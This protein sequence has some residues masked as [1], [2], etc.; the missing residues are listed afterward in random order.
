MQQRGTVT[1][2]REAAA[3]LLL[4]ALRVDAKRCRDVVARARADGAPPREVAR[5][6]VVRTARRSAV[7]G[8][9]CALPPHPA[10][11]LPAAG[12]ERVVELRAR[13]ALAAR[14]SYLRD[15]AFFDHA[16]WE[17]RVVS[18]VLGGRLRAPRAGTAR[19]LAR[20][21]GGRVARWTIEQVTRR[22]APRAL[23]IVGAVV[24]G[25]AGYGDLHAYGV[26]LVRER[27]GALDP[28]APAAL[29]PGRLPAL[30]AGPLEG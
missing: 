15:P 2:G 11:R 30:F 28:V 29:P 23:P 21:I 14:L 10:L 24:G 17:A 6:L 9:V 26:A 8:F 5:R 22:A 1:P 12:I 25:A 16:G 13:V 7:L 20:S 19:S 4:R 3:A 27:F 18:G